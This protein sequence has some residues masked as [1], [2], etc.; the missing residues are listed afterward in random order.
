MR[1]D[2]PVPNKSVAITGASSGIGAALAR[3]Y[4][5]KGC[6]IA[7]CGRDLS[8]LED[9]A[10]DCEAF[11][12][13]TIVSVVDVKNLS[14]VEAWIEEISDKNSLDIIFVN[15]GITGGAG[16][17]GAVEESRDVQSLLSTNLIGATN[18]VGAAVKAM[19][20]GAGGQI[21]VTN[22]LAGY[23]G[24]PGSPA[25]CA[26]KAGLRVYCESLQRLLKPTDIDLTL[27][28]PGYVSSPMS[29][30]V[31]SA[32]PLEM[33]PEKAVKLIAKAVEKRKKKMG[34]PYLMWVG[35]R[36]LGVLPLGLQDYL[37]P[38]FDLKV[39]I[40]KE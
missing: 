14:E 18:T 17:N 39:D 24:F 21:V 8:R 29:R 37:I 22:S 25:Y 32:K 26:S 3:Y 20:K 23:V 15:A 31:V 1:E 6:F 35:V 38:Y 27:I 4:A 10:R 40:G 9:V 11:G 34:F 36:I 16:K 19:L 7:L 28:F 33:T 12:A 13:N 5:E 30:K 2:F